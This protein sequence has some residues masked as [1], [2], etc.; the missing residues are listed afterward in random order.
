MGEQACT[1]QGFLDR[2][3]GRGRFDDP[4]VTVRTCVFEPRRFDHAQTRRDIFEFLG[5]RLADARLQVAARALLVRVGNVDLDA[6]AWQRCGQRLA[7]RRACLATAWSARSLAGI[8]FDRL[9]DGSG[10]IRQL[11]KRQSQLIRTHPFRLFAK[12]AL[13]EDVKLMAQ[14]GIL[15]LRARQLV[16]QRRDERLRR[17][18][19]RD[20][21][22]LRHA[23][24][25]RESRPPYKPL[26]DPL[27]PSAAA[28][29]RDLDTGEQQQQIRAAHLHR[30]AGRLRRPG[31]RALLEP[32]VEHPEAGAIPRQDLEPVAT[33]IA[34]KKEM[35]G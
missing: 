7:A 18:E 2:L 9:G 30:Q 5:N 11:R 19:V 29:L 6:V 35:T 3:R 1:G 21:A 20:V 8:H 23:R 27:V 22:C 10:L 4:G 16:A 15:A 12:E 32:F 25:I 17:G 26:R 33:P 13:T 14:R 28:R 24:I 34:K 31:K